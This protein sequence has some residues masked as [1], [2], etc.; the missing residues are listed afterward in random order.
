MGL[1]GRI[2]GCGETVDDKAGGLVD[3][4]VGGEASEA[5]ADGGVRLSGGE[6]E[7]AQ[8]VGGF[9]D[10]GGAGR[11]GGGGEVVEES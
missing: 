7:G 10:A 8:D 6:A 1:R 11:A 3:L 9:G 4:G 2:G 5:E